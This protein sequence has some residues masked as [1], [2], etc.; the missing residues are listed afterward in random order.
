[1][2]LYDTDA[3]EQYLSV[4]VPFQVSRNVLPAVNTLDDYNYNGHSFPALCKKILGEKVRGSMTKD[5][6]Y[7]RLAV[8][9]VSASIGYKDRDA[10]I[11]SG[12]NGGTYEAEYRKGDVFPPIMFVHPNV[13]QMVTLTSVQGVAFNVDGIHRMISFLESRD[14]QSGLM[15]ALF[16]VRREDLLDGISP[17]VRLRI[18][19]AQKRCTWFP[20]YQEISEVGL[21]GQRGQFHRYSDVYDFSQLKGKRVVEFGCNTGQAAVEAYFSG[22]KSYRGIDVQEEAITTASEI[23]S[24]LGMGIEFATG[25]FNDPNFYRD[26]LKVSDP[27]WDWSLFLAIYRTREIEDREALFKFIVDNTAE[28]IIFEGHAAPIDTREYYESIFKPFGFRE[29]VY[30]GKSDGRPAFVLH[31]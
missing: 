12:K 2:K 18:Q 1:M 9:I 20:S 22:A 10:Y 6:Q 13:L 24:I 16:V 15:E 26:T 25:D 8:L 4:D 3:S 21:V 11:A 30:L 29:I 31:K 19:T 27:P 7:D 28:G 17:E 14:G 23:N 5:F